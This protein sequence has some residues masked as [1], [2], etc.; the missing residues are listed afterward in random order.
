MAFVAEQGLGDLGQRVRSPLGRGDK[1]HR[2]GESGQDLKF[3]FVFPKLDDSARAFETI[4]FFSRPE[5][6]FR[7]HV[8]L[9]EE[10]FPNGLGDQRRLHE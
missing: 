7:S 2:P 9:A 10:P 8:N 5:D 1:S 3:G 4:V 6:S